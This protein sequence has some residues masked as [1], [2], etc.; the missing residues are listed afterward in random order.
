M[1]KL[2]SKDLFFLDSIAIVIQ[3]CVCVEVTAPAQPSG[4]QDNVA[5]SLKKNSYII[6][7]K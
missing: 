2:R 5:I 7:E 1:R 3:P 6:G 4:L